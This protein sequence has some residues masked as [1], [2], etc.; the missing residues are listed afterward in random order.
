MTD[1]RET[2][3]L[4]YILCGLVIAISGIAVGVAST[5]APVPSPARECAVSGEQAFS[6][7]PCAHSSAA[8]PRP[9]PKD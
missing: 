5:S 2:D 6:G 7:S 9:S 4:A 8:R 3:F 1:E